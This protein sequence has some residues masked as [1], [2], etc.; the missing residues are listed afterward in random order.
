MRLVEIISA[1]KEDVRVSEWGAE[2]PKRSDFPM[3]SKRRGAFPLTR[4]WR[5]AVVGFRVKECSFCVLIA[6]HRDLPEYQAVLAER[7]GSG[8][9]ADCRVLARL[10]YHGKHAVVG[11]HMHA[12]CEDSQAVRSGIMKPFGQRRIPQPRQR[13]RRAA[14]C[15][16]GES[17]SDIIALDVASRWFKFPIQTEM[18]HPPGA[19]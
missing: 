8:S 4:A 18:N 3:S 2:P 7:I 5:W 14:Y 13:H 19:K 11:W 15:L 1:E 16:S 12:C 17:M 10:K 6:Y 9:S